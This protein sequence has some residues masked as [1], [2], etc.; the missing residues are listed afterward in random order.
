MKAMRSEKAEEIL[1]MMKKRDRRHSKPYDGP[2]DIDF[3]VQKTTEGTGEKVLDEFNQS[4]LD[5]VGPWTGR[6][7]E[8]HPGAG[9]TQ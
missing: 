4:T 7:G 6:E 1:R 5:D 9:A 3:I 8:V 2:A